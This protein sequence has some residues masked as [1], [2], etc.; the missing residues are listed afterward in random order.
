[1]KKMIIEGEKNICLYPVN[2]PELN[3]GQY[4][5]NYDFFFFFCFNQ[6]SRVLHFTE[7]FSFT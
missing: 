6:A 5:R 3:I 1:M 4:N 7:G 2:E